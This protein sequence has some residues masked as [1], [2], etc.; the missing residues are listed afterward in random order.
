MHLSLSVK[1]LSSWAVSVFKPQA[2]VYCD[3]GALDWCSALVQVI[4]EAYTMRFSLLLTC[5][6]SSGFLDLR[7]PILIRFILLS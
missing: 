6:F 5:V 1:A 7:G 3:P 4:H 2:H